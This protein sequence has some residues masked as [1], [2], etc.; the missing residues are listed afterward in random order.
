MTN[1]LTQDPHLLG[2][3]PIV[4]V[5]N[6]ST[7]ARA[8]ACYVYAV[9]G[10]ADDWRDNRAKFI[11]QYGIPYHL[12]AGLDD[13][14]DPVIDSIE[15]LDY[16]PGAPTDAMETWLSNEKT[17]AIIRGNYNSIG[18]GVYAPTQAPSAITVFFVNV[19]SGLTSS[20][21]PGTP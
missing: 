14:P 11:Q 4:L 21:F 3:R 17:R 15:E 19:V 16:Y 20:G 1:K 10:Q 8:H 13:I 6:L 18:I 2:L 9:N 7:F 12:Y 5:T